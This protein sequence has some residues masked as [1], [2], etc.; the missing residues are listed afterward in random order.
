MGGY[1][2]AVATELKKSWWNAVV[3]VVFTISRLIFGWDWFN[4]GWSKMTVEHW[5]SDGKFNSGGLI[6][7]MVAAIQHS[8]GPDPLHLNDLLVWFSN[9]IF[10]HMGGLVDFLVVALEILIG[11]FIFFGFGFVWT[12]AVAIFLNLQYAAAGAA[13]NFGYLVTDIIWLKFPSYASLI[14]VDGYIRYRKGQKLLGV[15]GKP[16][17]EGATFMNYGTSNKDGSAKI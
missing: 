3:V 16:S 1:F 2:N 10:L 15:A 9:N 17:T 8:H 7:G 4:A 13:N 6:Q 11:L 5:L 14:G 12:I